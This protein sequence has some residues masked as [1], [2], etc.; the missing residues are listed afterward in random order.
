[1]RLQPIVYV[2]DMFRAVEF[3]GK[4]GLSANAHGNPMWTSFDVGDGMLGLHHVD[5]LPDSAGGRVALSFVTVGPLETLVSHLQQE[6][7]TLVREITDETFGR[8]ILVRDP[9]GLL[10]QINEHSDD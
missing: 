2:T 5:L 10:I 3:Y 9:D 4:L 8:S 1:M 7:I 6:G